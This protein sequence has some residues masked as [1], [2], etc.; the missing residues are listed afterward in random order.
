MQSTT[1]RAH[2]HPSRGPWPDGGPPAVA[3]GPARRRSWVRVEYRRAPTVR[4]VVIR[5]FAARL[6]LPIYRRDP[7]ADPHAFDY[8]IAAVLSPDWHHDGVWDDPEIS[9]VGP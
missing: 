7:D 9:V 8:E 1:I 5:A 6:G 4:Q 2:T 3:H